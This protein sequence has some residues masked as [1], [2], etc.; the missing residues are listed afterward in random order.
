MI[1]D[2]YSSLI[3]S[4]FLVGDEVVFRSV[5]TALATLY[6]ATKYLVAELDMKAIIF[7]KENINT[8]N[9]LLV[10]QTLTVLYSEEDTDLSCSTDPVLVSHN[11]NSMNKD[12]KII[13]RKCF[14]IIDKNA[15]KVL[16][17]DEIEDISLVLLKAIL[18]RDTLC[19]PSELCVWQ[20]LNRWSHRQCRRRQISPTTNNKRKV[21]EGAEM[22]VRYLTL[23]C[24]QFTNI[25]SLLTK[26]E[27]DSIMACMVNREATLIKSLQDYQAL[28]SSPRQGRRGL[29]RRCR[30]RDGTRDVIRKQVITALVWILD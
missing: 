13:Q 19:V 12:I 26:E 7:I 30:G 22:L 6:T 15:K 28:M 8:D 21:L 5:A 20:A 18:S 2:Y 1:I 4:S 23:T 29:W 25:T 27:E 9:V 17:G 11:D 3:L 16:D 10:L 14:N 24:H